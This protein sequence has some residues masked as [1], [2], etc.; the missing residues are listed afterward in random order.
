MS[1]LVVYYSLEGNTKFIAKKI[2]ETLKADILMLEPSKKYPT[3]GFTK[4]LWGGRS[5][6]MGEE[7]ELINAPADLSK[8]DTLIIGSPVWAGTFA[9]PVKTF[10]SKNK[11]EG[12]K[13][14]LFVCSGGGG[15]A[16]CFTKFKD[17]L[18]N[19]TFIGE[20]DFVEPKKKPEENSKK[21][22]KWAAGLSV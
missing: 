5:A 3:G 11:I 17:A 16:K 4:Y 20:A 12:K 15:T 19:N 10:L 21:A 2:A 14:A 1:A 22:Q 13:I 8:Y 9:P 7:P 6:V 18:K